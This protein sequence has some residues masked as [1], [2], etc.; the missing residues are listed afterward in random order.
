MLALLVQYKTSEIVDVP[1]NCSK[2]YKQNYTIH[3]AVTYDV[4]A[5]TTSQIEKRN[6]AP[7]RAVFT[8][9]CTVTIVQ[10]TVTQY[11]SIAIAF[12]CRPFVC[13]SVCNVGG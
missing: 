12:A 6:P 5:G 8:A 1:E 11:V 7:R 3:C 4:T 9:R 10:S 2:I 13:P